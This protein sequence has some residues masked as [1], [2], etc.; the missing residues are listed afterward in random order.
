M[1]A[2]LTPI[3]SSIFPTPLFDNDGEADESIRLYLKTILSLSVGS[4]TAAFLKT[5]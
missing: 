4:I 2:W 1:P 3:I 5:K